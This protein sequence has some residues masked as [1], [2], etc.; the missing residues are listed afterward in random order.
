MKPVADPGSP[1]DT[2]YPMGGRTLTWVLFG[3]NDAKMKELDPVG[4]GG[5]QGGAPGSAKETMSFF[6]F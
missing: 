4:G 5:A 3:E 1:I 2:A 6:Q